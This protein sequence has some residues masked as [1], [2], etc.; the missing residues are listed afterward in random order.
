MPADDV[1]AQVDVKPEAA[2]VQDVSDEFE[3]LLYVD[4]DDQSSRHESINQMSQNT[5]VG[6]KILGFWLIANT[7][8]LVTDP[9]FWSDLKDEDSF[10]MNLGMILGLLVCGPFIY[11]CGEDEG[12]R[13]WAGGAIVVITIVLC[14]AKPG[15]NTIN[16][17]PVGTDPTTHCTFLV[18]ELHALGYPVASV[19]DD[20]LAVGEKLEVACPEGDGHIEVACSE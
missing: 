9:G 1:L 10:V 17:G 8:L 13:Q 15:Y 5:P 12:L 4:A 14:V 20:G 6:W 2:E 7:L 11:C 18:E 3:V 19:A 16:G